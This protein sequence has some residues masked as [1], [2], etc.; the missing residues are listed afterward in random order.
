MEKLP[1]I[2]WGSFLLLFKSNIVNS[3]EK[4][5]QKYINNAY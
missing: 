2:L 3:V 5:N 1:D 4:Q